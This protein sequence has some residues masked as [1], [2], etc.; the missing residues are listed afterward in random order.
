MTIGNHLIE[1]ASVAALFS[2]MAVARVVLVKRMEDP[3]GLF[4]LAF[5]VFYGFRALLVASGLDAPSPDY[6]FATTDMQR[7]LVRTTFA[8]CVF[9]AVF[10]GAGYLVSRKPARSP[11]ILF[12]P[13]TPPIHRMLFLTFVLT[14]LSV[15]IGAVLITRF[16]GFGGVVN[17]SKFSDDLAGLRYLKLPS[18]LGALIAAATYMDLRTSSRAMP[19]MKPAVLACAVINSILVFSWGQRSVVVIVAAMLVMSSVKGR[20]VKRAG[21]FVRIALATVLVVSLAVFLRD[22]R[23][24]FA[25]PGQTHVFEKQTV[26]RR[27]S[28]GVNGTYFDASM[29]AFRDWPAKFSFRDGEDFS[30]GFTGSVPRKLWPD[31]PDPLP[32]KWFRQVYQPQIKNGWPVGTP[33]IWYLN[34]GWFGLVIGGI[35]SGAAIGWITRRYR[36]APRS[37]LNVAVTFNLSVFVLPLGWVSQAPLLF[38]TWGLPMIVIVAFLRFQPVRPAAPAYTSSAVAK[39]PVH[40]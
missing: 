11:G 38:L 37:G 28:Q 17:A 2:L 9:L 25:Q 35:L 1:L 20:S 23:D 29:L 32:G 18:S 15:V 10:I 27:M 14:G 12:Y 21:S 5:G 8:L 34:F 26:W 3:F 16:G 39:A 30:N 36:S 4:L 31:K 13:G 40:T 19:F 6:L 24:D 22:T 33:T 7:T